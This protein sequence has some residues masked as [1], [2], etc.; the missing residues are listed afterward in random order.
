MSEIKQAYR[1]LA[2]QYHPDKNQSPF[3]AAHFQQ[4]HEAYNILSHPDRRRKYDEER[5]LNGMGTRLNDQRII[6]AD[7]ILL[8]AIKLHQHIAR[9]DTYRMSHTALH[10]YIMLLLS[11]AHLAILQQHADEELN[12]KIAAEILRATASL[13]SPYIQQVATRLSQLAEGDN[14]LLTDIYH[15]QQRRL[16]AEKRN[17]MIPYVVIAITILLCLFM[18]IYGR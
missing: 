4:L 11:D 17:S 13:K 7:W 8:E 6:T 2:H 1:R 16:Q 18:Y 10:D 14:E 9:M 12:R 3:A 15:V 5:W